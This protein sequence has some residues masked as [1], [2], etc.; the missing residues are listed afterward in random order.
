MLRNSLR[1]LCNESIN[2]DRTIYYINCAS[3]PICISYV[4]AS[5]R[6]QSIPTPPVPQ[7]VM[8]VQTFLFNTCIFNWRETWWC[9]WPVLASLRRLQFHVYVKSSY[10]CHDKRGCQP[11]E[12][13]GQV[14][15]VGR[16]SRDTVLEL[17]LTTLT[18]VQAAG[19][20]DNVSYCI[21]LC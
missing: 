11:I 4:I 1:T 8:G 6:Q 16:V 20:S 12:V 3:K 18:H 21:T 9:E 7:T 14:S 5:V 15:L 13:P 2:L 19:W 10:H 17:A